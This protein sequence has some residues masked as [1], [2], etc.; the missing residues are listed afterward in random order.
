MVIDSI[1]EMCECVGRF[2]VWKQKVVVIITIN[3]MVFQHLCFQNSILIV[4]LNTK[5]QR[6]SSLNSTF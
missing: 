4:A 5:Q 6:H 3:F 2:N 1:L